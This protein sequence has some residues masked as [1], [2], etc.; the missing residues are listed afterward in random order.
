[1]SDCFDSAVNL[2]FAASGKARKLYA[3]PMPLVA[4]TGLPWRVSEFRM[5]CMGCS[6][7]KEIAA[8]RIFKPGI[9]RK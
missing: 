2:G 9:E 6:K 3:Q 8:I 5:Q 1:M 4:G 7:T